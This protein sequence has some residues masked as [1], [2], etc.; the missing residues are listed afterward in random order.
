VSLRLAR[1]FAPGAYPLLEKGAG[2]VLCFVA[3]ASCLP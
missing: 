2:F 1:L 3:P